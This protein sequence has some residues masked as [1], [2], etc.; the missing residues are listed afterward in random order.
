MLVFLGTSRVMWLHYFGMIRVTISEST[1]NLLLQ[2]LEVVSF[3]S[4]SRNWNLIYRSCLRASY[5]S[6]GR[7]ESK[8]KKEHSP[9][10]CLHPHPPSLSLIYRSWCGRTPMVWSFK[11]NLFSTS[12]WYYL[13][14]KLFWRFSPWMKSYCYHSNETSS[15]VLSHG[16]IYLVCSSNF[17]VCGWNPI[18][19]PFEWN[20]FSST[21]PWYYLYSTQFSNSSL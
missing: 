11:W 5:R 6:E 21:F 18:L 19:L 14:S 3:P 1:D 12:A 16:T 8:Q 7:G 13:F 9:T 20:L 2:T 17:W 4:Y 10:T 15:A